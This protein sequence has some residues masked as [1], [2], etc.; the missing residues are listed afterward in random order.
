MITGK[1]AKVEGMKEIRIR[2]DM[3]EEKRNKLKEQEAKAQ[4]KKRD[5]NTQTSEDVQLKSRHVVRKWWLQDANEDHQ[6]EI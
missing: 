4:S 1:L 5:E 2:R 6:K 3:N